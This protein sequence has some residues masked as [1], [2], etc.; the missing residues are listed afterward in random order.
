MS[1]S[2][3]AWFLCCVICVALAS[4]VQQY[5]TFQPRVQCV[6]AQ[7]PSFY[8]CMGKQRSVVI[9]LLFVDHLCSVAGRHAASVTVDAVSEQDHQDAGAH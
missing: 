4:S 8:S 6:P 7:L 5:N 3:G 1:V 9:L 2:L